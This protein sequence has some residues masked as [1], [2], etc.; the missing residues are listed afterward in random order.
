MSG[1]RSNEGQQRVFSHRYFEGCR[2]VMH[3]S[4]SQC[5]SVNQRYIG[6]IGLADLRCVPE[7]GVEYRLQIT[8]RRADYLQHVSRGSLL[9]ERFSQFVEQSRIFNGDDGLAGKILYQF[10]LFVGEWAHF[11]AIYADDAYELVILKHRHAYK[12]PRP[13]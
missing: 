1:W 13:T 11:L 9:L 8:R 10:N 5:L 12:R 7:H 3:V 2:S 6:K 4:H